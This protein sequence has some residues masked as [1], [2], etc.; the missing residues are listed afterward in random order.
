[1][2]FL[3]LSEGAFCLLASFGL[4][5]R[6]NFLFSGYL[7]PI[8]FFSLLKVLGYWN[9]LLWRCYCLC[10]Q[11]HLFFYV[12]RCCDVWYT[13]IYNHCIFL[14]KSLYCYILPS[15]PLAFDVTSSL[16][17]TWLWLWSPLISCGFHWVEWLFPNMTVISL[18]LL[19]LPLCGMTLIILLFTYV[20]LHI[21]SE[22][23]KLWVTTQCG[24][25]KLNVEVMKNLATD[26]GLWMFSH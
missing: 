11:F 9:V 2:C 24:C 21:Q 3:L 14:L 19:W 22:S 25:V 8:F 4:E 10:L 16:F 1:M 18:D 5:C 12:F 15:L 23:F 6:I 20:C 13:H 26:K 7:L 17:P